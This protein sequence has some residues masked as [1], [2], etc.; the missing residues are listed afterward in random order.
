KSL[1]DRDPRL[2]EA[3]APALAA[4]HGP[5]AVM[6]FDPDTLRTLAGCL[7]GVARGLIADSYTDPEWDFIPPPRR[8]ALRRLASVPS[9]R[10]DFL[11]YAVAD[12]PADAPLALRAEGMPLLVWTVRTNADRAAAA[13]HADQI[14]FEGF[15]PD[16]T[17]TASAAPAG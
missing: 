12:L 11:A 14:I 8:D 13:R 2:A 17:G 15:D 7:P 5:L 6:S 4:Y 16:A 10:P 3:A 1:F 9:D